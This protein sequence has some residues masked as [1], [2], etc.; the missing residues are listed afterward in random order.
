MWT[1]DLAAYFHSG[2]Y[3]SYVVSKG[4]K[5][6][7]NTRSLAKKGTC[8]LGY[9]P[10]LVCYNGGTVIPPIFA[11]VRRTFFAISAT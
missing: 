1:S 2:Y 8:C 9:P 11:K 5:G 4:K 7:E 3:V 6:K 10:F